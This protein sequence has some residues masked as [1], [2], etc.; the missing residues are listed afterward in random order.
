MLMYDDNSISGPD[1]D[2]IKYFRIPTYMAY[3]RALSDK[4][5]LK[6]Y[7][8]NGLKTQSGKVRTISRKIEINYITN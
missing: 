3:D 4:I 2:W 5:G 6:V 8:L 1:K 7:E